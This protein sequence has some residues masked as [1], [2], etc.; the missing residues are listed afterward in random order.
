MILTTLAL[1]FAY[2]IY[3][4]VVKYLVMYNLFTKHRYLFCIVDSV[5]V[6]QQPPMY[7]GHP[8]SPPDYQ[9]APQGSTG[10]PQQTLTSDA[11]SELP[12]K[13]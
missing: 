11:D 5:A 8:Q 6:P 7:G 2:Q 3:T 9:P 10:Y 4:S 13:Q 12:C 1:T